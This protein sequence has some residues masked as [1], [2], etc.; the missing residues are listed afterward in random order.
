MA[1]GKF[2]EYFMKLRF[3]EDA[4]YLLSDMAKI[5]IAFP[6]VG[7]VTLPIGI[8][9]DVDAKMITE[10]NGGKEG[11]YYRNLPG[12]DEYHDLFEGFVDFLY[13]MGQP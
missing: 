11:L 13:E 7:L 12:V 10:G 9:M 4:T 3:A 8:C 5:A 2:G 1:K 6:P